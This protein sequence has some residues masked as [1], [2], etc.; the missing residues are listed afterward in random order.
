MNEIFR[1]LETLPSGFADVIRLYYIEGKGTREIAELL[2]LPLYTV[3]FRRLRGI[4][5]IRQ[6]LP[7]Y[8]TVFFLSLL[9]FDFS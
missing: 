3:K 1:L 4:Q 7:G 6:M 8:F 9:V 5:R 2:D